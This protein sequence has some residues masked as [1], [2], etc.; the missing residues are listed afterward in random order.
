VEL[1]TGHAEFLLLLCVLRALCGVVNQLDTVCG[2]NLGERG[3]RGG[4]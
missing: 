2:I 3:E 4:F 1:I